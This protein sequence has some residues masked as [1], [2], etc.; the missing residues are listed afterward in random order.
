MPAHADVLVTNLPDR[1]AFRGNAVVT[2]ASNWMVYRSLAQTEELANNAR[3]GAVNPVDP[4]MVLAM[5]L[6]VPAGTTP[7]NVSLSSVVK[8]P[9]PKSGSTGG[10]DMPGGG[11]ETIGGAAE[12][13]SLF[14]ATAGSVL[15]ALA[16]WLRRRGI[17][18]HEDAVMS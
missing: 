14:L 2:S 7:T 5:V 9:G 11:G 17:V 16:T 4:L 12:P 13:G 8:A 3:P 1:E 6:I 15:V 18:G 10:I